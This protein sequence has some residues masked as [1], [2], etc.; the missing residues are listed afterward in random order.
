MSF[1]EAVRPPFADIA[2]GPGYFGTLTVADAIT[3]DGWI[4]A[5][6]WIRPD[7][8][9]LFIDGERIGE[10]TAVD[11]PDWPL[12]SYLPAG[13][14][15]GF[16][17]AEVRPP[18]EVRELARIEVI[19][20][21]SGQAVARMGTLARRNLAALPAPPPHLMLRVTG[22]DDPLVVKGAGARCAKELLET[23]AR[24]RPLDSVHRILDWGCGCARVT[25][26][27]IDAFAPWTGA[28]VEGC[29]L[30]AE[31]VA[32]ANENVRKGAFTVAGP[33]PPL[34]WPDATFDAVVACSVFTH[35][36]RD[37]QAEWLT[38]MQRVIAPGGLLLASIFSNGE[39]FADVVRDGALDGIAPADYYRFTVQS[40]AHTTGM[41]SRWFDV[42][43]FVEHGLEG[44][45]HLVVLRRRATSGVIG[46]ETTFSMPGSAEPIDTPSVAT[47]RAEGAFPPGHF[48][49]PIP[50]WDEVARDAGR[51][52][53][54][55]RALPGIDLRENEQVTLLRELSAHYPELPY[56]KLAGLR[57][58]FGNPNFGHGDAIVLYSMIRHLRPRRI[59]EVGSGYSS[60]VILDTNALFLQ[61]AAACTFVDPAPQLLESLLQPDDRARVLG[62]RVQDAPEEIFTSLEA[63]DVFF[64]DS[65][66]VL[67]T[68]SDVQHILFEILPR[69]RSGVYV[70]FHDVF[71]PFEYPR[72]W[73]CDLGF[74]WNEIYAVHAFLQ[75]NT[76]FEIVFFNSFLAATHEELFRAAMPLFLANPGGSL[77]L[78]RR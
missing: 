60:A 1:V 13:T 15:A 50:D 30:D 46:M 5:P 19:A 47:A 73:V 70:H 71:Y 78:R 52:F 34:P 43:E 62:V 41:W 11:L 65:S 8:F 31:A 26:H 38:E 76:A 44:V 48:Y 28:V 27:L 53:R 2:R 36:T 66:H 33:H 16:T 58:R 42:A 63:N 59:V 17:F 9:G 67:K 32:W 75:Y 22:N 21:V 61:G 45:Q 51:V 64:V 37:A 40:R 55:T 74:A 23:L 24:H 18:F 14:A 35:L 4:L 6:P 39:E 77:W 7:R 10:T 49:S 56:G 3:I 25:M 54:A 72:S 57:Y 29:D 12:P 69:L 68:G 20:F